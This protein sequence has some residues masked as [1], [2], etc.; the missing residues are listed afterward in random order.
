MKVEREVDFYASRYVGEK[1][2]EHV[3]Y[4]DIVHF[5]TAFILHINI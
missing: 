1:I 2:Q 5:I 4:A 3:K